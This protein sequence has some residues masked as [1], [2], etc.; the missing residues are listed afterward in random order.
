MAV[1]KPDLAAL[2]PEKLQE[3]LADILKPAGSENFPGYKRGTL[4]LS[5]NLMLP[6]EM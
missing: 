3:M 6:I 1:E 5:G 4:D 2:T